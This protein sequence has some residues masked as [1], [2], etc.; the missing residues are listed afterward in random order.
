MDDDKVTPEEQLRAVLDE[1]S[2]PQLAM[3]YLPILKSFTKGYNGARL[4]KMQ[5]VLQNIIGPAVLAAE[6]L[7]LQLIL[8]LSGLDDHSQLLARL[9]SLQSVLFV[10]NVKIYDQAVVRPT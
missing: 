8:R 5:N 10:S 9:N 1:S 4:S 2:G 7:P 6:P 3:T